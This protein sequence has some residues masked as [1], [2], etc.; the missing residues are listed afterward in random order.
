MAKLLIKIII[1]VIPGLTRDPLRI[2]GGLRIKSAMTVLF[3]LVRVRII[4]VRNWL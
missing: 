2:T 1:H 4:R 3:R